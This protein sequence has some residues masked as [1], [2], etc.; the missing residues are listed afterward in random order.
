MKPT[1]TELQAEKV[2]L[3]YMYKHY[4]KEESRHMEHANYCAG[5]R[6]LAQSRIDEIELLLEK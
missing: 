1:K 4:D 6:R 3:E 5:M 2:V